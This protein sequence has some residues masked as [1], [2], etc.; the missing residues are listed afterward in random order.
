MVLIGGALR[1][2]CGGPCVSSPPRDIRSG[3]PEEPRQLGELG[4]LS[5]LIICQTRR[6]C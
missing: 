4:E 3:A 5:R 6:S 2:L 1:E